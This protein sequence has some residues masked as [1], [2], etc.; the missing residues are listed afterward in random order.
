MVATRQGQKG[1]RV[2]AG[3]GGAGGMEGGHIGLGGNRISK[4][5][6]GS[7]RDEGAGTRG[8]QIQPWE[9]VRAEG[10]HGGGAGGN[11]TGGGAARV[12]VLGGTEG[13]G[14]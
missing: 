1:L 7:W 14:E 11:H 12:R 13:A 5:T 9:E 4:W 3:L 2:R 8:S 6:M 10:Q